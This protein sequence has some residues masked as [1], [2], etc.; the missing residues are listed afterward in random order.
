MRSLI[1][2]APHRTPA[3]DDST[4]QQCSSMG[5]LS[6]ILAAWLLG[7]PATAERQTAARPGRVVSRAH[8]NRPRAECWGSRQ[9]LQRGQWRKDEPAGSRR[10]EESLRMFLYPKG[11]KVDAHW[12]CAYMCTVEENLDRKPI[13]PP[14]SSLSIYLS[15]FIFTG[16]THVDKH[17]VKCAS[18][19]AKRLI[20]N[21]C[22]RAR[23]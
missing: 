12:W 23:C 8:I 1:W 11:Q 13:L 9:I 14:T 16:A 5:S 2:V 17:P 6:S 18:V 21:S 4:C 20:F 15:F 3:C 19:L 7:A 22:H 10:D